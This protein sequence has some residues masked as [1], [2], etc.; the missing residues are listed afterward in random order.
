M[1]VREE[2][3]GRG[4]HATGQ[5]S[6]TY[7]LDVEAVLWTLREATWC[8]WSPYVSAMCHNEHALHTW[9][10]LHGS[11]PAAAVVKRLRAV[12]HCQCEVP[13]QQLLQQLDDMPVSN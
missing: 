5:G 2:E 4:Y 9:Y 11:E 6:E 3:R 7:K 10:S 12:Q 13:P 1:C 8:V